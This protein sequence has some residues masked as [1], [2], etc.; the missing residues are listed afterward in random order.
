MVYNYVKWDSL[1]K[2]CLAGSFN[3]SLVLLL[4]MDWI[5]SA[6]C[7]I[8]V[9]KLESNMAGVLIGR[10]R[11]TRDVYGQREVPCEDTV[12]GWPSAGHR[13][14]P[15]EKP[16]LLTPRS[17]TSGLQKKQRK[18]KIDFCCWSRSVCDIARAALADWYT[19]LV[20]VLCGRQ[21][22][23][24]APRIPALWCRH[25]FSNLFNCKSR[26]CSEGVLQI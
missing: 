15:R 1:Q 4:V 16:H 22:S 18:G 17:W 14:G 13:E 12:G 5:V 10:E 8:H 25:S 11:D 19:D 24:M 3:I 6:F 20:M 2:M 23:E 9:L 21:N 26:C 7:Q